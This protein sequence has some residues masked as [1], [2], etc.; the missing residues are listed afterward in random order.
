LADYQS[1]TQRFGKSK[2]GNTM[3]EQWKYAATLCFFVLSIFQLHSQGHIVPNGV[4]TNLFP[5]EIDLNWP[6]QTQVNGFSMTP[7][8]VQQPTLYTNIFAFSEP[9]TIG[10]RVF[11]VSL[12]DPISLQ[13]ITSQ[14]YTELLYP[15]NYVFQAGVPVY[16]GLYSGANFAPPYPP[17]PPYTYLDP[18][19]GWAELQNVNGTIKL[20][21]SALEYGGG[22]IYAG[23]QTIIPVPE[24]Q[25]F[26]LIGLGAF[27]F[28]LRRW[29]LQS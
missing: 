12:N 13:P 6:Q 3:K 27:F 20:L 9:V 15:D 1:L 21:D 18:V 26:A 7:V 8:G 5:G 10:V 29:R 19:F 24:P 4:V 2:K 23:T 16:V 22:G 25:P 17:Y 11:L 28:G 14:N